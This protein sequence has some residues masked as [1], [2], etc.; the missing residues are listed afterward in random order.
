MLQ[1]NVQ[2]DSSMERMDM[3][4]FM[5]MKEQIMGRGRVI[6]MFRKVVINDFTYVFCD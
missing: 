6:Y 2:L 3:F 5:N 1:C 4:P